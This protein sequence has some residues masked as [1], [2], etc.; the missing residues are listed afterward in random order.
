MY[1]V[2]DRKENVKTSI[3]LTK[4]YIRK[5]VYSLVSFNT[6]ALYNRFI[7]IIQKNHSRRTFDKQHPAPSVH[8]IFMHWKTHSNKGTLSGNVG[9]TCCH[10]CLSLGR[11]VTPSLMANCD[12]E[13]KRNKGGRNRSPTN[14]SLYLVRLR[15]RVHLANVFVWMI[16]ML[17]NV[18]AIGVVLLGL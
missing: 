9:D 17:S 4:A 2:C 11:R 13:R 16:E 15:K 18:I 7:S 6:D 3:M 12:S 1:E 5:H 8:D 10:Y 14:F